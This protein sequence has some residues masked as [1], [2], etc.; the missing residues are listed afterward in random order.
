MRRLLAILAVAGFIGAG[1]WWFGIKPSMDARAPQG[2][3]SVSTERLAP[4]DAQR[5]ETALNSP[6]RQA[7]ANVM[8]PDTRTAYLA[9]GQSMLPSGSTIRFQPET[10]RASGAYGQVSA[11]ITSADGSAASYTVT[12][13][14]QDTSSPWLISNTERK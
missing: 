4:A 12:L 14:R 6:D 8:S 1:V 2:A 5:F 10:L 9:Q 3:P 13:M 7:Q 11:V